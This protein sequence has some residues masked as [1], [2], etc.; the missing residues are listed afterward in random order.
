MAFSF[1][2]SDFERLPLDLGKI[3]R[4]IEKRESL[5]VKLPAQAYANDVKAMITAIGLY[6]T[7]DYRRRVHVEMTTE[8]IHPVAL[9]GTDRPDARRHEFGF[10]GPDSLGRVYH[11][12]PSPHWRPAWD[13]N[14][15]KYRDMMMSILN[16]TPAGDFGDFMTDMSEEWAMGADVASRIGLIRSAPK[17]TSPRSSKTS[18][19]RPDLIG[20][21]R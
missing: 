17:A 11:Q 5:A 14:L 9:I 13:H 18:G 15:P 6:D 16:G 7:G 21:S 3:A 20:R 1:D 19:I 10:D 2:F 12:G 8:G 4:N